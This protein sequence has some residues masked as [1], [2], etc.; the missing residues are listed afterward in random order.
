MNHKTADYIIVFANILVTIPCLYFFISEVNPI[1]GALNMLVSLK[2][3]SGVR[4]YSSRLESGRYQESGWL[5]VQHAL[6]RFF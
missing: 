1:Y 2:S 5:M 6:F 3:L 4:T